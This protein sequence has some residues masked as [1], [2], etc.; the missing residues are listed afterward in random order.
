MPARRKPVSTAALAEQLTASVLRFE[1]PADQ[2][3]SGFFKRHPQLG[4][5]DRAMLADRIWT[6]LVSS[7]VYVPCGTIQ[8]MGTAYRSP[9]LIRTVYNAMQ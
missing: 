1:H 4:A 9:Y 8:C 2:V 7:P 3:I 5:R 6:Q